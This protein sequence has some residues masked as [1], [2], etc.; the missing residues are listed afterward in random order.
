MPW[1]ARSIV[2]Q[3]EEFVVLAGVPGA[4]LSRL[5]GRFGISRPT[6]YTWLGRHREGGRGALVD[7]SRRPRTSPGRSS[8]EVERLVVAMRE[9]HPVWGG[10]KIKARLE[11]LGHA[12]IPAAS[13]VTAILHRHG[14]IS[15]EASEAATPWRR[16]E[17][18]Q[19]NDLW[20]MDFKGP[21]PTRRGVCHA[22]TVLDDHS[23]FAVG[24]RACANQRTPTVRS[25]LT[26][27]FEVYG[28]P[29]RILADNGPP[30][31]GNGWTA[32]EV[33]LLKLGVA[34]IH[35]RPRH[36]Q[37][38]G[39]D[40]RFHRTLKAE[41]LRRADFKHVAH[42]QT[43]MDPWRDVYN[44]ERPHEAVGLRPPATR[45]RPSER[46]MP[47]RP[48]E[49]EP[50]A[51]QAAVTVKEGGRL[52]HAGRRWYLGEAWDQETVGLAENQDGLTDVYFGPYLIGRLDPRAAGARVG[53]VPVGRC[54]PS[55]HESHAGG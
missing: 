39:K 14:L 36:P 48:A 47:A 42:A 27:L 17:H 23:R 53:L 7:R 49:Y 3:R 44:L 2:S 28:L 21:I 50:S 8:E 43:L 4:N 11:Q 13:T 40:E 19:P 52:R 31:G 29:W 5:C 26:R 55:L 37:T 35:G 33:W 38:Q 22:L 51:G 16:F 20:Q 1:E 24:L 15:P 34:V 12:G 41:L 54:A 10:R 18:E 25:S 46:P 45:Y 9:K 30:W 6:G 32:L